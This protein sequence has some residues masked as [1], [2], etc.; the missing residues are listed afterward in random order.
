MLL[1]FGDETLRGFAFAMMVG[2]ASGTYSSI[3][4]ASP[5]L[6]EWKER[7]PA[8]R[9]RRRNI[10][11]AMGYVPVFPEDNVVAR[12]EGHE[13]DAPE[14]PAAELDD[15]PLAHDPI[16]EPPPEPD[17][18]REPEPPAGAGAGRGDG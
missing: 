12:V 16:T 10:T 14:L 6:T 11:E 2:I 8:Y 7:E 18:V 1:I 15:E 4:I 3:F 13:D 9:A 17:V 5:V